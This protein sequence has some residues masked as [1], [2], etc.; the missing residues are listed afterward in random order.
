MRGRQMQRASAPGLAHGR[1][2][3]ASITMGRPSSCVYSHKAPEC[4]SCGAAGCLRPRD[5]PHP[6]F[7]C[8]CAGLVWSRGC[9]AVHQPWIVAEPLRDRRRN[10]LSPAGIAARALNK[11]PSNAPDRARPFERARSWPGRAIDRRWELIIRRRM[12]SG[13]I[14]SELGKKVSRPPAD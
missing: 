10:G 7:Q 4:V 8:G 14:R 13:K 12:M 9:A 11:P 3:I 6:A 1:R 5:L 2:A